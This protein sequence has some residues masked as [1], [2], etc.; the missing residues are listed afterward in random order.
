[1]RLLVK[2]NQHNAQ[3]LYHMINVFTMLKQYQDAKLDINAV[4][5]IL[6]LTYFI[7]TILKEPSI[8]E[9]IL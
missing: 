6:I 3:N 1:L 8:V 7:M 2:P 9:I 4:I 5:A